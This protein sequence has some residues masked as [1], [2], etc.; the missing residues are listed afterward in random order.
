MQKENEPNSFMSSLFSEEEL[1][2]VEEHWSSG[3]AW[4]ALL[5]ICVIAILS[6]V[7][8]ARCLMKD[9]DAADRK[10]Y[11]EHAQCVQKQRDLEVANE[12]QTLQRLRAFKEEHKRRECLRLQEI[13]DAKKQQEERSAN[14]P[15]CSISL[16]RRGRNSVK[17]ASCTVPNRTQIN[18]GADSG[19][20]V[21]LTF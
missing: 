15:E 14:H 6:S 19:R 17:H 18:T 21:L 2:D 3:V 9:Q 11:E 1:T 20:A 7:V 12:E 13:E 8:F 16:P 10:Y 5:T 4:I